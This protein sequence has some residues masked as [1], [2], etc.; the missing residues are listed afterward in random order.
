MAISAGQKEVASRRNQNF[1]PNEILQNELL[2]VMLSR[3]V[4]PWNSRSYGSE[5]GFCFD[6]IL[7]W[8]AI[9]CKTEQFDTHEID[10]Q[11]HPFSAV[12]IQFD[13]FQHLL[14]VWSYTSIITLYQVLTLQS[15]LSLALGETRLIKN[16]CGPLSDFACLNSL[17]YFDAVD[18]AS[19]RHLAC[20]SPCSS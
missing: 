5:N 16:R 12:F 1:C 8:R 17:E 13:S 19:G 15:G 18:C 2:T 11:H 6:G 7:C 10:E 4:I 9:P 3:P 20:K 14:F